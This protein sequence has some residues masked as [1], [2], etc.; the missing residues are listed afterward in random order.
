MAGVEV[1]TCFEG[2]ELFIWSFHVAL[3]LFLSGVV[4]KLTGEWTRQKTKLNFMLHKL[5]SLGVPYVVFSCVYIFINSLV[6]QANTQSSVWD[7]LYI[8]KTPVAQ[9]WFLYALFFLFCIWSALS[10]ILKNWQITLVTLIVGYG[11]P[12]LNGSLGCFDVVFYSALAFGVGTFVN[13]TKL[14]RPVNW[15]KC[16][17]VAM[18]LV[19]SVALIRLGKI[20]TPFVKEL[21]L[22]F[23]IYA[24]ILFISMLQELKPVASFLDFV[25]KYSFQIYLLH[26]IFTAGIRIVLIRL[27]VTQWV[28]HTVVGTAVGLVFSVAAAVIA[29]K[30]KP[31][32][33]FFF[34]TKFIKFQKKKA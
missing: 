8:W 17:V 34:P 4:Y 22:L 12:L 11:V 15:I 10:G 9:Y 2:I 30:I 18:H 24:S 14:S 7:I 33:F 1:P 25:N 3:F 19:V 5:L 26:T 27:G 32:D 20:E 28:I 16:L 13:F 23:G 6:G 31:L 29:K 21:M